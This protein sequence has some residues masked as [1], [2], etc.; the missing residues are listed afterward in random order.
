M[1]SRVRRVAIGAVAALAACLVLWGSDAPLEA[2]TSPGGGAG[3]VFRFQGYA[4]SV[5]NLPDYQLGV[6]D[7]AGGGVLLPNGTVR[8]GRYVD[9]DTFSSPRFSP[10]AIAVRIQSGKVQRNG[11]AVTLVLKGV[12]T[13]TVHYKPSSCT[14]GAKITVTIKDDDRPLGNGQP[15]DYILTRPDPADKAPDGGVNCR[16]HDHGW[17]NL[18]NPNT[19]PTSGGR[20]GG[21]WADVLI[22]DGGS[23]NFD[24]RFRPDT[25]ALGVNN[26]TNQPVKPVKGATDFGTPVL[27]FFYTF[28]GMENGHDYQWH[29]THDGALFHKSLVKAWN[30]GTSGTGWTCAFYDDKRPLPSGVWGVEILVDGKVVVQD[31]IRIAEPAGGEQFDLDITDGNGHTTRMIFDP[32]RRYRITLS[33]TAEEWPDDDTIPDVDP[34]YCI[35]NEHWQS[36]FPTPYTCDNVLIDGKPLDQRS[37]GPGSIPYSKNHVYS[38]VVTGLSG[39]I[40]IKT[41]DTA[42][43]DNSGSFHVRIELLP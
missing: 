37:G 6:A 27:C 26:Q 5:R 1:T 4:N 11:P 8:G 10:A 20:G 34:L 13:S 39:R 16:T 17:T 21:Y 29:W 15:Q 33:G 42:P 2:R 32:S 30:Q 22:G 23:S 9:Y 18:D 19:E 28:S 24:P 36:Y 38:A 14:V 3:L 25:F 31:T 40:V 35:G 41:G 12:V 7:I 43:H